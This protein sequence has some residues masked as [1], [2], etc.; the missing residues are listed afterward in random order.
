MK[1]LKVKAKKVGEH[2][3]IGIC[4]RALVK[5]H[6]FVRMNLRK[7]TRLAE[8]T[9][10]HAKR[11]ADRARQNVALASVKIK[12]T[13]S[14]DALAMASKNVDIAIKSSKILKLAIKAKMSRTS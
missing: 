10:I 9:A 8:L 13:V 1:A 12:A 6:R 3:T 2:R 5:R 14:S 7:M 11:R 4:L